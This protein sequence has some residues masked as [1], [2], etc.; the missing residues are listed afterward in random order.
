MGD[1]GSRC[2]VGMDICVRVYVVGWMEM[3]DVDSVV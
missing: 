1:S 3:V 2:W